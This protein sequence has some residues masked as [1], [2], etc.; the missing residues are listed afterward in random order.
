[1]L[2]LLDATVRAT[3]RQE[4]MRYGCHPYV[5]LAILTALNFLNYLDRSILF[6]VQPLIW[7]EFQVSKIQIGL[8]TTAFMICFMAA[9]ALLGF[10]EDRIRG[11]RPMDIA[12]LLT[13]TTWSFRS[14]LHSR[15][16]LSSG[17][18]RACGQLL[19]CR[20]SAHRCPR[21]AGALYV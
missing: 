9:A 7:R 2:F 3:F 4:L 14:L 11:D 20:L 21:E 8:L 12:T 13:A 5:V 6:Q 15:G 18:D 1:M 16:E 17:P 19:I 10:L